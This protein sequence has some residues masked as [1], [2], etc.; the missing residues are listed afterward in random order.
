M[1]A[2]SLQSYQ[3][4]YSEGC[5]R[6]LDG[7]PVPHQGDAILVFIERPPMREEPNPQLAAFDRFLASIHDCGEEVPV[8]E[9]A[10]LFREVEL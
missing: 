3:G 5:S 6:T 2:Q 1:L 8:F 7:A 4:Y 9:R 10:Q